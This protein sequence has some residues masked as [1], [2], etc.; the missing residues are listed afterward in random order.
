MFIRIVISLLLIFFLICGLL[1]AWVILSY[2]QLRLG[3]KDR[4]YIY[5][6]MRPTRQTRT[7]V[8]KKLVASHTWKT[9]EQQQSFIERMQ[10]ALQRDTANSRETEIPLLNILIE[11]APALLESY[12]AVRQ[13]EKQTD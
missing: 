6:D 2:N 8:L 12:G 4:T 10:D 5:D 3:Q 11:T 9:S 13:K 1:A 7:T